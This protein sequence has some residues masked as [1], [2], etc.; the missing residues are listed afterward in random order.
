MEQ[1][2]QLTY[3]DL[4]LQIGLKDWRTV[5]LLHP[6]VIPL[7]PEVYKGNLVYRA[8]GSAKRIPDAQIKAGLTKRKITVKVQV[9]GSF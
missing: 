7:I 3:V 5:Y 4:Q 1:K 8:K 6:K 2:I 9:P